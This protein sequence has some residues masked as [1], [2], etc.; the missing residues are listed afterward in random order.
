MADTQGPNKF[1]SPDERMKSAVTALV[2]EYKAKITQVIGLDAE[3]SRW[4]AS[5]IVALVVGIFWLLGNDKQ[6]TV[7]SLFFVASTRTPD[8]PNSFLLLFIVIISCL[9]ILWLTMKSYQ[10]QQIYYYLH[11]VTSKQV[12]EMTGVS[13]NKYELYLR[14]SKFSKDGGLD[15][16]RIFY[17]AAMVI[18]PLTVS[19][20]IIVM[21]MIFILL[22]QTWEVF[23]AQKAIVIA[24]NVLFGLVIV[25]HFCVGWFAYSTTRFGSNWKAAAQEE[26]SSIQRFLS[27]PSQRVTDLVEPTLQDTTPDLDRPLKESDANKSDT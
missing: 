21:Y 13:F 19:A 27:T 26:L 10:I 25:L 9:Y 3:V 8:Y 23:Y 12:S 17:Y 18:L 11:A 22:R 4:S 14:S 24:S 1:E 6:K 7:E 5:Y 15:R 2:E 20:S 16:R